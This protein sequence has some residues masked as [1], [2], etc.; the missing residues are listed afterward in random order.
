MNLRISQEASYADKRW[1][2]SV[3][4]DGSDVELDQVESVE[5]VLHPTFPEPIVLVNERQSKF[6]LDSF[7]WGEFEI[8]AHVTAKD[9]HKQHL[10]HW[11]RLPES[12]DN[13]IHST[14]DR[15][16]AVFI[17]ASI[18]DA[19]WEDAVRDA[20]TRRGFHVLTASDLPAGVPAD[21]AISSMLD[22][23]TSVVAIFGNKS[24]PWT[25]REVMTAME[26]DV[27]VVPLA[28]GEYPKIRPGLGSVRPVRVS[29]FSDV[30]AAIGQIV[31][32]LA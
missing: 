28:V 2:W 20:L 16:S 24:G 8:N 30:D 27:S 17:S 9:G 4:I 26:K 1:D 10:K 29:D 13:F 11:L 18:A 32:R 31:D 22:K 3:W 25:E 14:T 21:T 5:W 6:R 7:G 19:D 15:K 23:A 12:H